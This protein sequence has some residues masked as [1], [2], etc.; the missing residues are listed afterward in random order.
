M[1][2]VVWV[3]HSVVPSTNIITLV[4]TSTLWASPSG[5]SMIFLFWRFLPQKLE[6]KEKQ[7]Y[8]AV[9]WYFKKQSISYLS[10][11]VS[12]L[13]TNFNSNTVYH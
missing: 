12:D 8:R 13:K 11:M 2:F 3:C 4:L 6:G 1:E 7:S 9:S 5:Q 10:S